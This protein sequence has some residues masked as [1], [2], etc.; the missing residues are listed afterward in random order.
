MALLFFAENLSLL[1][2]ALGFGV[3]RI[4]LGEG[5]ALLGG[6]D[7][8][9]FCRKFITVG[10]GFRVLPSAEETHLLPAW[11]MSLP[12]ILGI[13]LISLRIMF[14]CICTMFPAMTKMY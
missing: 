4:Y 5:V 14:A 3:V 11:K 2:W 7:T 1:G 12:N 10:V 8:I 13:A 9:I 6:S